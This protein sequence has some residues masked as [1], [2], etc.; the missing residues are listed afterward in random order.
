MDTFNEGVV[1]LKAKISQLAVLDQCRWCITERIVAWVVMNIILAQVWIQTDQRILAEEVCPK[2]SDVEVENL[3]PLVLA[4]SL[5]IK[6]VRHLEPGTRGG[7]VE[8]QRVVH[9]GSVISAVKDALVV[10]VAVQYLGLSRIEEAAAVGT[11]E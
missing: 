2:R 8:V 4:D 9:A 3:R 11:V 10:A 7:E 1:D 6:L 5:L